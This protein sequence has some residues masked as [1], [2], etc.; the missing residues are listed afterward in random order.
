MKEITDDWGIE[1]QNVNL[2]DISF[3]AG[4]QR[5]MAKRAE[6]ERLREAKVIHAESEVQT[7]TKLLEAAREL[8][9]SPVAL[10]LREL[11]TLQQIAK[12]NNHSSVF[13]PL[14]ILESAASCLLSN[15]VR[16]STPPT[17]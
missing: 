11:D 13:I 1:V 14:N 17:S 5:A 6:A 8:E 7:A 12:E 16:K 9:Q 10:R 2:K 15:P 4:M 3:D